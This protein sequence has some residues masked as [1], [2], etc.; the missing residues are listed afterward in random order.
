MPRQ[1]LAFFL[2]LLPAGCGLYDREVVLYDSTR[3]APAKPDAPPA[4]QSAHDAERVWLLQGVL[5]DLNLAIA[6]GQDGD[7]A[8]AGKRAE[9]ERELARRQAGAGPTPAAARQARLGALRAFRAEA[10]EPR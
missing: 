1:L 9:V 3:S 7:G 10:A 8:L 6:E 5:A 2:L 4:P